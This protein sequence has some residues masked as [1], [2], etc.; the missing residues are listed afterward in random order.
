ML[1]AL[2]FAP[3]AQ[4]ARGFGECQLDGL[5]KLTPGLKVNQPAPGGVG[6]N[7]GPAFDYTFSGTLAGCRTLDGTGPG[8]LTGT[9]AAGEAVKIGGV[10]YA[11][12]ASLAKPKGNGGCTGSH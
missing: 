5:A 12:P 2:A 4:A 11:W 3:A 8:E 9:I 6:L 1:A 10:D 7:W